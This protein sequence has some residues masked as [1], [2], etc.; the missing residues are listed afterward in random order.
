[1]CNNFPLPFVLPLLGGKLLLGGDPVPLL[2]VSAWHRAWP[3]VNIQKV[4]P[5]S[6]VS[7]EQMASSLKKGLSPLQL[8]E[9][10]ERLPRHCGDSSRGSPACGLE[11]TCLLHSPQMAGRKAQGGLVNITVPRGSCQLCF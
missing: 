3:T 5:Q 6:L 7:R 9:K 8:S 10:E 2:Y 4:L 1:M 11:E